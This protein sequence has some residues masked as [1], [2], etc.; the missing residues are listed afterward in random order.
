MLGAPLQTDSV[1]G[2]SISIV[3]FFILIYRIQGEVKMM[4]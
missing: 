3:A 2:L 4:I 1:A